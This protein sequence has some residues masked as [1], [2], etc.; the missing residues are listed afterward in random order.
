MTREEAT[1]YRLMLEQGLTARFDAW[2]NEQLDGGPLEGLTLDLAWAKDRNEQIHLLNDYILNAGPTRVDRDAVLDLVLAD[3]R[4][5]YETN[6]MPLSELTR[7]MATLAE[8]SDFADDSAEWDFMRDLHFFYE[9]AEEGD[10]PPA[11]FEKAFQDFL[12]DK[13]RFNPYASGKPQKNS[14]LARFTAALGWKKHL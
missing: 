10:F 2:L 12:H 5:F 13:K 1:Y 4:A 14:L 9:R 11:D 6:A 7:L 3:M 8:N